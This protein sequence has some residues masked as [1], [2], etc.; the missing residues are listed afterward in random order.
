MAWPCRAGANSRSPVG[1]VME[2]KH[3][4]SSGKTWQPRPSSRAGTAAKT[5]HRPAGYHLG[6]DRAF[7]SRQAGGT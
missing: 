1:W 2:G 3:L 5:P 6:L 4:P 7:P